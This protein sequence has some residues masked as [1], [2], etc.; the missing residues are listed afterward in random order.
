MRRPALDVG[1]PTLFLNNVLY[2][3]RSFRAVFR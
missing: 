2:G 3:C 1:A